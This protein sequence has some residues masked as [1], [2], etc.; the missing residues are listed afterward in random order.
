[1]SRSL[2][3]GKNVV[4]YAGGSIIDHYKNLLDS[5]FTTVILNSLHI[6]DDS[7]LWLNGTEVVDASGKAQPVATQLAE[8]I[9]ELRGGGIT[10]VLVSIGGGGSF[11]P[12]SSGINGQ[13]SVS[14][15]DF[16]A[17]AAA[18]WPANGMT[19]PLAT[20]VPIVNNFN[21]FISTI[22]GDGIDLDPEPMFYTYG[23]L[24]SST[25][26]LTEWALD[27]GMLATWAPYTAQQSWQAY[28][29]ALGQ[30]GLG[31]P[32]TPSWVNVQTW[33]QGSDLQGWATAIG[34]PIGSI[35]GGFYNYDPSYIQNTLAD[36]VQG[37][38]QIT[39]AFYWNFDDIASDAARIAN[40]ANAIIA[41]LAGTSVS[42]SPPT[43][44]Y[45]D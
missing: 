44:E 33:S 42:V 13:H 14:D 31:Q 22:G 7:S 35:I 24:L 17:F 41:G 3:A 20:T 16:K 32:L 6:H 38:A 26:A 21:V 27:A 29:L 34:V 30:D 39:G 28:A 37:G 23:Q 10:T 36:A 8:I 12:N 43:A 40:V 4:I 25:V 1:M 19:D 5:G 11:N 9:T 15:A 2:P 18:Y 45:Q